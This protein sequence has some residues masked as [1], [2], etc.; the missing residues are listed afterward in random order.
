M[1]GRGDGGKKVIISC[2]VCILNNTQQEADY[3]N[4]TKGLKFNNCIESISKREEE[5][6][7]VVVIVEEEEEEEEFHNNSGKDV[8]L[9]TEAA[10]DQH[11]KGRKEAVTEIVHCTLSPVHS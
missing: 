3:H 9:S 1:F 4:K 2:A 6:K 10:F 5:E 7:T 8:H 11:L